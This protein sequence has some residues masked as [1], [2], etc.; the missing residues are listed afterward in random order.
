MNHTQA[1]TLRNELRAEGQHTSVDID[2][3]DQYQRSL[4]YKVIAVLTENGKIVDEVHHINS[5]RTG[6]I[7][8]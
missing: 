3:L 6:A 1:L 8:I 7:T 5:D 2:W 4:G